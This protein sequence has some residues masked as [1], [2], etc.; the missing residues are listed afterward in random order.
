MK[1]A[2]V[3]CGRGELRLEYGSGEEDIRLVVWHP[4]GRSRT[5]ARDLDIRAWQAYTK[6]NNRIAMTPN[7]RVAPGGGG[8]TRT[9]LEVRGVNR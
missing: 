9:F 8:P 1:S 2:R 7:P 3:G 6:F 4:S 5:N